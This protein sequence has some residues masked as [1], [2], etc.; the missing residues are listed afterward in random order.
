MKI[1]I[2]KKNLLFIVVF[3]ICIFSSIA[4]NNNRDR[5]K[6]LK[7]SFITNAIDLTPSEA[8]KFWP[9]YNLHHKKI[10][11]LKYKLERG[12]FN[13]NENGVTIDNINNEKAKELVYEVLN[14]ES[15]IVNIKKQ[16]IEELSS[17]ISSKK[18]LKL[19]K[20]ERDFNKR[21]LQEFGK[22]RRIMNGQ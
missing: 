4:Q 6:M 20:A 8:E 2:M 7:V 22:R 1:N 16:L 9:I 11:Q 12:N 21:M 19:Q 14:T 5:I 15:E 18:I 10:N 3:S 13:S 17:V